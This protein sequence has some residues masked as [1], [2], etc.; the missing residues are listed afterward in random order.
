[1]CN[2]RDDPP[3]IYIIFP[4][5]RKCIVVESR[6]TIGELRNLLTNRI[7]QTDIDQFVNKIFTDQFTLYRSKVDGGNRNPKHVFPPL[8]IGS[9]A[10]V[11]FHTQVLSEISTLYATSIL[12]FP[13]I[14]SEGGKRRIFFSPRRRRDVELVPYMYGAFHSTNNCSKI[15]PLC[16]AQTRNEQISIVKNNIITSECK[17]HHHSIVPQMVSYIHL[18]S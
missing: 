16:L 1:M 9:I 13:H 7:G 5:F 18:L 17:H 4:V 15:C 12:N 2:E 6:L 11:N 8:Y 14:N 10:D 3:I